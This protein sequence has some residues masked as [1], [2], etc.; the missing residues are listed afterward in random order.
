MTITRPTHTAAT[1]SFVGSQPSGTSVL[2]DYDGLIKISNQP[3]SENTPAFHIWQGERDGVHDEH[4][5]PGRVCCQG[6]CSVCPPRPPC[7]SPDKLRVDGKH[8]AIEAS[9]TLSK[10]A[11]PELCF[12]RHADQRVPIFAAN[13]DLIAALT[14]WHA[15]AFGA[16]RSV[17]YHVYKIVEPVTS[18]EAHAS[19]AALNTT[20]AGHFIAIPIEPRWPPVSP[21]P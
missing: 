15:A 8:V 12:D 21:T 14:T 3:L 9:V 19:L 1:F 18:L 13:E 5:E 16:P 2:F 7:V 11:R 17:I 4:V 20:L 10:A 6:A